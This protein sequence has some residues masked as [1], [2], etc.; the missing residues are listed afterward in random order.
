LYL[1]DTTMTEL[2]NCYFCSQ[3][4]KNSNIK[5]HSQKEHTEN[6]CSFTISYYI[7]INITKF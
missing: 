3:K 6:F 7:K 4:K 5:Q 2:K 1:F